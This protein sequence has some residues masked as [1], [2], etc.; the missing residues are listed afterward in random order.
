MWLAQSESVWCFCRS[1]LT[2]KHY[3]RSCNA[4]KQLKYLHCTFTLQYFMK[5]DIQTTIKVIIDANDIIY[6]TLN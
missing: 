4:F 6:L 3:S 5:Y 2:R 1:A